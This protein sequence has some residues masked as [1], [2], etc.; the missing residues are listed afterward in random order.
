MAGKIYRGFNCS[1][2]LWLECGYECTCK[3]SGEIVD[4]YGGW[5]KECYPADAIDDGEVDQLARNVMVID[6][7]GAL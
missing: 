4:A 3:I 6:S 5:C 1:D 7:L 2:C